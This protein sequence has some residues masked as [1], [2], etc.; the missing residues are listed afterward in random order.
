MVITRSAPAPTNPAEFPAWVPIVAIVAG[1]LFTFVI[2]FW[3]ASRQRDRP[4]AH[5]LLVAV[6][7]VTLHLG[8]SLGAGQTL[9]ALHIVA[10]VLK[11][12]AGAAAGE[13]ARRRSRLPANAA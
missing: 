4:V 5:G 2:G 3:R 9:T 12:V 1:S 8:S 13:I 10:D 7:A 6:G 11:L